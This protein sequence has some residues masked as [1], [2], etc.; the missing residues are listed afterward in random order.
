MIFSI[1][2]AVEALSAFT[3][4]YAE[5]VFP[6]PPMRASEVVS[7]SRSKRPLEPAIVIFPFTD[8]AVVGVVVP[9][10]TFPEA[11][12]VKRVEVAVPAVVDAMVN[13]GTFMGVDAEFEIAK[14]EYGDVVP[15]PTF[16]FER[17]VTVD[18]ALS[19]ALFPA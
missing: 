5:V 17:I 18:V 11:R 10:P 16:P 1:V 3:C 15:T 7:V 19:A 2:P 4:T 14:I 8:N 9:I 6:R 12:T 13:K